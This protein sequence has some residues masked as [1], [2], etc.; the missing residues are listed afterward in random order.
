[1]A[2]V[3]DY[4]IDFVTMGW[5]EDE[6]PANI[7]SP[8]D[9]FLQ[10]IQDLY[11]DVRQ[12]PLDYPQG[13]HVRILL[14]LKS[15]GGSDDQRLNVINDLTDDLTQ[16]KIERN[17]PNWTVEIAYHDHS[18][19]YL[20]HSHVKMMI[21]DGKHVITGGYNMHYNYLEDLNPDTHPIHD[22][23]IE[24]SSP[25]AQNALQVFDG[26]WLG[27]HRC[28]SDNCTQKSTIAAPV[29]HDDAV[30]IPT[31]TGDTPVFSLFRDHDDGTADNAIEAAIGAANSK[32]DIIQNRFFNRLFLVSP[33]IC[34]RHL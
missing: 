16:L 23:G 13:V 7:D 20:N 25:V 17:A 21:V 5:D 3:A 33:A 19:P 27:A 12:N 8:G 26:L 28:D 30:L 14:G 22:M 34:E 24:I 29:Y 31:I 18:I 15:Y 6:D 11:Q 32:V 2:A 1:M 9:F 4:E 10:G